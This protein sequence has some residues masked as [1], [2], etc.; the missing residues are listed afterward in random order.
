[1]E[2]SHTSFA[3]KQETSSILFQVAVSA[4][5]ISLI[6]ILG[7]SPPTLLE[8]AGEYRLAI[9]DSRG[10]TLGHIEV[11]PLGLDGTL[12]LA[13]E[14]DSGTRNSS[15]IEWWQLAE[16][17]DRPGYPRID[18]QSGGSGLPGAKG[19]DEDPAYYSEADL[20]NRELQAEI[21][22]DGKFWL[23]D[24]PTLD[25]GF[26]FESW[27]VERLGPKQVRKLAGLE[28]GVTLKDG[29]IKTLRHPQPV[30]RKSR[31]DWHE[32]L[33]IS[34]FGVGWEIN[35]ATRSRLP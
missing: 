25:S 27:L 22:R 5:F 2:Q 8:V 26:R 14:P 21:F 10:E 20:V 12:R 29:R 15:S 19:E 33:R 30:K 34:G 32:S 7:E 23:L 18:P 24:R 28:W 1:M 35:R 6:M 17:E 9:V 4:V 3:A 16:R 31:F 13:F 11:R